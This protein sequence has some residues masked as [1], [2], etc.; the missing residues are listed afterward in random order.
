MIIELKSPE[1]I[2]VVEEV[3]RQL[4]FRTKGGNS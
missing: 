3:E 4:F 2:E 1:G